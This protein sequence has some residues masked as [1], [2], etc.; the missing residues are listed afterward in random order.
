[1][2][3]KMWLVVVLI[4]CSGGSGRGGDDDDD[5]MPGGSDGSG[6]GGGGGGVNGSCG[7]LVRPWLATGQAPTGITSGDFDR[8]GIVDLAVANSLDGSISVMRG[9]GAGLFAPKVDYPA[10][11][12]TKTLATAD[13]DHD[14]KLDL[15][16]GA[17]IYLGND[18]G[19]FQAPRSTGVDSLGVVGDFD[20]DGNVDVAS[21][22]SFDSTHFR[23]EVALGH[24]DAT[25]AASTYTLV[26]GGAQP[27]TMKTVDLNRDGELDLVVATSTGTVVLLGTG[28]GTF[29]GPAVFPVT[30]PF[31]GDVT[32]D[33]IL[34]LVAAKQ[35]LPGIGNGSFGAAI[36][37][38][39][40][41]VMG[42]V[43]LDGD[44]VLD[45]IGEKGVIASHGDGM[46]GPEAGQYDGIFYDGHS[47][48]VDLDAD[49]HDDL[50][51]VG[52]EAD[53][54]SLLFNNAHGAFIAPPQYATAMGAMDL[55]LADLGN[56]HLD[57]IVAADDSNSVSVL[58]GN[59][60]GTFAAK[61]DGAMTP[62]VFDFNVGDV[63][64]D[65]KLDVIA[66]SGA[67][68]SVLRGKGDGTLM[69]K[70][71]AAS[72]GGYAA[73]AD[74][75]SDGKADV[76]IVSSVVMVMTN[77]AG[78][79]GAPTQVAAMPAYHGTY[80]AIPSSVIAVDYDGNHTLDLL[81]GFC[82]GAGGGIQIFSGNGAGGFTSSG[83]LD[84]QRCVIS[85]AAGDVDGDGKPDVIA[86][87]RALDYSTIGTFE[88][89]E[90]FTTGGATSATP[91]SYPAGTD[92]ARTTLADVDG[93]GSLDIVI[94]GYPATMLFNHG[95]GTF[96]PRTP[97][98]ARGNAVAAADIDGD[99]H[100]DL[101]T[102]GDYG[103]GQSAI[104]TLLGQCH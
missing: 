17:N 83:Q 89:V 30:T 90:V 5:G 58:A 18:D 6:S 104:Q 16:D 44:G 47:L 8:D 85:V 66:H 48:A 34:D 29:G 61:K 94:A 14:G 80:T 1:M 79:L 56:G 39:A 38:D 100:L 37:I 13:F 88:M 20:G 62:N 42:L 52:T 73:I 25:F 64:G 50:A 86:T 33:G 60:D 36:A 74:F 103:V 57:A 27:L 45:I 84:A 9:L 70:T 10:T 3:W 76:A 95:N 63:D 78:L 75:T 19:S 77:T 65:G 99:G 102:T 12:F 41:T 59:G 11:A 82:S 46:F 68:V 4:G 24:G 87:T 21:T 2:Q 72:A 97:V 53:V 55:R 49:G 23:L 31:V 101:V 69:A 71:D 54:V 32:G 98:G 96:G 81:V 15:S 51:V 35:V 67:M 26:T 28:T 93:D 22:A 43:D 91:V 7:G 40:T 92:L